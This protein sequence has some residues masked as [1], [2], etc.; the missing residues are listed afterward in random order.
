MLFQLQTGQ[1]VKSSLNVWNWKD[2]VSWDDITDVVLDNTSGVFTG[3][4]GIFN[5]TLD[6]TDGL[7]YNGEEK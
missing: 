1:L 7:Y 3:F 6:I 2:L 4:D 5:G